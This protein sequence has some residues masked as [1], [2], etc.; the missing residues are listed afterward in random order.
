MRSLNLKEILYRLNYLSPL[1]DQRI[2]VLAKQQHLRELDFPCLPFASLTS[3]ENP[4]RKNDPRR[5]LVLSP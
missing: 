4:L 5:R 1:L 3:P 2:S